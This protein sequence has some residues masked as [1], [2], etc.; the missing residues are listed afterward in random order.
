MIFSGN[1]LN[2]PAKPWKKKINFFDEKAS[3]KN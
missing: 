2:E 3:I 1:L